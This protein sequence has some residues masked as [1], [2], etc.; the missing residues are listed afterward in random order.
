MCISYHDPKTKY[1]YIRSI[2]LF[3]AWQTF[4]FLEITF[5]FLQLLKVVNVCLCTFN[6]QKEL[7]LLKFSL[8]KNQKRNLHFVPTLFFYTLQ[9][10]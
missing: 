1:F 8:C 4:I 10:A 7:L 2:S 3:T 5:L 6:L 9:G